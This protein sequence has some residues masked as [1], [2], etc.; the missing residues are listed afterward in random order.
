MLHFCTY[1]IFRRKINVTKVLIEEWT[2]K[3]DEL[4]FQYVE[5]K[6]LVKLL[7]TYKRNIMKVTAPFQNPLHLI[8]PATARIKTTSQL[9]CKDKSIQNQK[10]YRNIK[11]AWTEFLSNSVVLKCVSNSRFVFHHIK[12]FKTFL[13]HRTC[14][15]F[16]KVQCV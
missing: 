6:K 10:M 4:K 12:K 15:S 3:E 11:C 1:N 7:V 2:T 14:K 5:F 16:T 13:F 8:S 9:L